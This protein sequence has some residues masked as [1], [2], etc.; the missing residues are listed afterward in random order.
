MIGREGA[1]GSSVI[2][3][4][5]QALEG[6]FG[7]KDVLKRQGGKYSPERVSR[8]NADKFNVGGGAAKPDPDEP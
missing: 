6:Y 3:S 1:R 4:L 2:D 8:E 7:G 5:R